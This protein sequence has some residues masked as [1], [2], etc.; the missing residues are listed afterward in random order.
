MK[1]NYF[2]F[3]SSIF[4]SS[5]GGGTIIGLS[6]KIHSGFFFYSYAAIL[7]IL[8]DLLIAKYVVPKLSQKFCNMHTVG[9]IFAI[10]YGVWGKIL[11]G[12]IAAITSLGLVAAQLNV[13]GKV[14]EYI[15]DIEYVYGVILSLLVVLLYTSF[16]GISSILFSNKIQ[17]FAI[18]ISIPVLSFFSFKNMDIHELQNVI[19]HSFGKDKILIFLVFLNFVTM[20]LFPNFIQRVT[21]TNDYKMI[22]NS[23]YVKSFIYLL[24]LIMIILNAVTAKKF[25]PSIES[26]FA[27][28]AIINQLIPY[29]LQPL[30]IIGI[31][32]SIASTI[33][34]DINISSISLTRDVFQEFFPKILVNRH[35][36]I[37][38]ITSVFVG[39]IAAN[40]AMMFDYVLDLV[41][42]IA[43]FWGSAVLPGLLFVIFDFVI[44]KK[45]FLFCSMIGFF[46]FIAYE[47]L[48]RDN[49]LRGVF[50]GGMTNFSCL[51]I[52]LLVQKYYKK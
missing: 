32:A 15:L 19:S 27:L 43:G 14:F 33:D 25:F 2:I 41:I 28:P 9:E 31:F 52:F 10:Y 49:V 4:V 47:F 20:N 17:F 23:I 30:I 24:L 34:S 12:S 16:G 7:A 46:I 29:Y 8:V 35:L 5:I 6:E 39:I 38:K 18:V 44:K 42:F 48:Y 36:L 13:S 1:G 37:T 50:W 3:I 22:Q 51:S 40:L 11:G 45:F 21:L 26:K